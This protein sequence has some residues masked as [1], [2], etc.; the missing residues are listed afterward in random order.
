MKKLVFLFSLIAMVAFSA[1]VQAQTICHIVRDSIIP[2]MASYKKAQ[3]EAADYGKIIQKQVE[4]KQA[5]MQ[6]YYM[7]VQQK[8]QRGEM[9]PVQVKEAEAKLQKMQENYQAFMAESEDKLIAKE[10]DLVKPVFDEF[11]A[12]VT[13]VCK[14]DNYGYVIDSTFIMYSAGGIDITA[15][16]K[17]KLG[18]K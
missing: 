10:Q 8:Q 9:T 15:K 5:E 7:D 12:A 11:N 6:A 14:E 13:A 2:N 17:A 3:S 16:V 4:G 1:T 18:L